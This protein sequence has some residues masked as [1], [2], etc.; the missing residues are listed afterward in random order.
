MQQYLT[1]IR[2]IREKIIH[3]EISRYLL[4]LSKGKLTN[5]L[6]TSLWLESD[7]QLAYLIDELIK[8]INEPL[9]DDLIGEVIEEINDKAAIRMIVQENKVIDEGSLSVY[10]DKDL[11]E[12]LR[13][14][15]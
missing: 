2:T 4:N 13:S 5:E 12:R 1:D 10:I 3:C 7:F 8:L 11:A 9:D 14:I 6:F 15:R